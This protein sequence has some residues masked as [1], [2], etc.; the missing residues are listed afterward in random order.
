VVRGK[1]GKHISGNH[2]EIRP[3]FMYTTQNKKVLFISRSFPPENISAA[4]R[5]FNFVKYLP[6]FGW[7]PYVVTTKKHTGLLDYSL[8]NK[9]DRDILVEEVFSLDPDNL[10]SLF[11]LNEGKAGKR[12]I[13]YF[14]LKTVLK[15]YS[16]LYYRAIIIDYY[17]G[18]TPCGLIKSL[19]LIKKARIDLIYVHGQPPSS[20]VV[21]LFIKKITGMPLVIDYDDSWTTSFYEKKQKNIKKIIRQRIEAELL[22]TADK[23]IS[24]KKTTINEIMET[25]C[26]IEKNKFELITNGYDPND[27]AGFVKTKNSEFVITYTGTICDKYYYSPESF[28]KAISELI[29]EKK[30]SKD[31]LKIKFIGILIER[32]KERFLKLIH[33]L[34]IDD[35][36]E[37][38]G[39]RT[40]QEC[41]EYQMKSDLLLYIIESLDGKDISYQYAGVLPAKI[42]EYIY[43]GV[44]ILAIIPPGFEAD[45]IQKAKT[46]FVAEP[47]NVNSIK[48]VLFEI[49]EKYKCGQLCIDPNIEEIRKY[50]RR[51]LTKK[52]AGVFDKVISN[53]N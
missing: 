19:K 1:Q 23:V 25:F 29:A 46:G 8:L 27:F 39:H 45:L 49:Y 52:L 44:P 43:T 18:W 22:K 28:L 31:S 38:I 9:I 51:E 15:L 5:P 3:Q 40:H 50:D 17:D 6:Q 48:K 35:T 4:Q 12:K 47:N 2:Q 26:G 41:I 36:I 20:F 13:G 11:R 37:I 10:R 53:P 14:F 34:N 24:V 16:A 33:E 32:Y 42:F 21:G 7:K 30:L